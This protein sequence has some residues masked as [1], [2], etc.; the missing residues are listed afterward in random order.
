MKITFSSPQEQTQAV[1]V[2][3]LGPL[4]SQLQNGVQARVLKEA[5]FVLESPTKKDKA[6]TLK[7]S[8]L[9]SEQPF[10]AL[11]LQCLRSQ[12]EQRETLLS[13][14]LK[15][16]QDYVQKAKEASLRNDFILCLN[17][18]VLQ[19]KFFNRSRYRN[20]PFFY[21]SFQAFKKS[22]FEG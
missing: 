16:L 9:L 13:S 4:I 10:L 17:E 21:Q 2:N 8:I 19:N 22:I 1:G 18:V 14:L 7:T 3:L 20:R 12:E 6:G 11:V 15:Q 5:A